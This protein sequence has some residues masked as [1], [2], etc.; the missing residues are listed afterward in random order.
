MKTWVRILNFVVAAAVAA[1]FALANGGQR[2]RVELG[3]VTL[4]SVSLPVVVFAA[5]LLGMLAVLLAGL[6][7]DLRNRRRMERARRLFERDE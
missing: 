5:V 4:R 7:A 6:R 2:V 1:A 3:F